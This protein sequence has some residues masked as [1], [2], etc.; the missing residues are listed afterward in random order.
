MQSLDEGA[1]CRALV[2][3]TNS[4]CGKPA[5]NIRAAYPDRIAHPNAMHPVEIPVCKRHDIDN[6][7]RLAEGPWMRE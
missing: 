2:R 4:V 3:K 5:V 7:L 1:T 6:S